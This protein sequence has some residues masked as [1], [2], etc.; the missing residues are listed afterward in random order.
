VTEIVTFKGA[1]PVYG[2]R[3]VCGEDVGAEIVKVSE[4]DTF[5]DGGRFL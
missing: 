1:P 5:K 3:C 4:I 2:G